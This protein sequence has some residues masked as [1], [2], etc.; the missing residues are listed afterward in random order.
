MLTHQDR[1]YDLCLGPLKIARAQNIEIKSRVF[2]SYEDIVLDPQK[3]LQKTINGLQLSG[4]SENL[5]TYAVS[6]KFRNSEGI[7]GKSLVLHDK[8]VDNYLDS[9]SNVL[10]TRRKRVAAFDYL[11]LLGAKIVDGLGYEFDQL[12]DQLNVKSHFFISPYG[13]QMRHFL[14]EKNI[15]GASE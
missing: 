9:W 5:G 11:N 14:Q 15:F 2:L 8:V 7:D 4:F 3:E 6:D 10:N 12:K 1:R 13:R